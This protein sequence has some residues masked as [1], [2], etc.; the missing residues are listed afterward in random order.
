MCFPAVPLTCIGPPTP[1]TIG[2]YLLRLHTHQCRH[3]HPRRHCPVLCL[4]QCIPKHRVKQRWRISQYIRQGRYS[5]QCAEASKPL[6]V[7]SDQRADP[8]RSRSQILQT[9]AL[10]RERSFFE[11]QCLFRTV[12]LPSDILLLSVLLVLFFVTLSKAPSQS[13]TEDIPSV[14]FSLSPFKPPSQSKE[15]DIP[16]VCSRAWTPSH[17]NSNVIKAS[18]A[19]QKSLVSSLLDK[20]NGVSVPVERQMSR[21]TMGEPNSQREM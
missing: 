7:T 19:C 5:D 14:V 13:K 6:Q 8:R 11:L 17:R 1:M 15:E 4:L 3:P 20:D 16:D 18:K 9:Q 2:H 10:S 21:L 12:I